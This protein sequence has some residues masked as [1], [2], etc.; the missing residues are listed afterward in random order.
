MVVNYQLN[1]LTKNHIIPSQVDEE[2]NAFAKPNED[3]DENSNPGGDNV[4]EKDGTQPSNHNRT[5]A[6]TEE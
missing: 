3:Y 4:N 2:E 5:E 6:I 1:I